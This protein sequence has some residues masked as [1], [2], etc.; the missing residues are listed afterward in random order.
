MPTRSRTQ[1]FRLAGAAVVIGSRPGETLSLAAAELCRFLHRLSGRPS[2]LSKGLPTRGAALVLDRAAAARLGVAPAA[3]EVGDQGYTLRHV[4]AGGRA[5]LVIAAATDV[6]VLYGV[7]GLLEELGMGFHAGGETYP[8]RPAPCTLPAGFEQTRRPVFPVRGNMLHY[9]FLCG[10]TDWGLDDYKF[11][12]DQLARMRCNLLLMHWYDGE[13]GAAYEFN[14]EYLAGGRTPNSLTRP[15]GALAALRTSQFSFDTARCFDAEVYSSP[16]GENLPDLLS[17]VKATETAWREATRYARTAGIRIAA[18]FEEPGGSPTDGAVCERF[19]ARLRQFLARNPHIT[20]FALW[21]HESGGCYGTT[22][23][24]A[25]TPAAALLER[26]RHLFTHLGTDRRIWEAVRYGGFAEIAAQVLAEEAPHLRLVVVGWGGDRWMRFADLCL[27]FDKMLPADVVFTCHDNIDASFGPNVSTPWG[28]L[29]PSRERWAMPWVEGDIDECWV[30][31]PHVESL[32]QLAPD[33]LRKGAQGLLTLQWRT[34]DV[35]EET[36]YIARFAWNPRLTPEQ[37]YRDLARHAFGADNEARMG[38][39]LG[40]LQCLG[41]RWSGVRGTVE[42]GHMQWTG[43]SPHFPFNL[44]ASVPPFLADM[45]D[46]AVDALSIMPRD[47]NDPEAGAF[48]A[49]RNDMSGEETVRDPS[50][51]GVR[52]MTAVAARL[53]ALA[54]E[55]DP[56]RLRA[57]LIAIEEE[58]WALRKVLVERGMSSLA[59]R[60][61]DIFLI[62]IHHLQRNAGADTH[63]PRLDELQKEL[64]TL[65]RRFVKAGRLE[66]LERLDYLAAT[67]DFVRHYDRVAMLAAAGEA[68]DRAVASA[69]TALAAGQAGRAAATAAEAYTALLEAGMQRAIEA[70]TGKLTTRCDFGTLCTLNVKLLP[71]YWETVDR[72]TRF[73]PAVPPREIQARGKADAVW[74]SWEA[75]PKAA[76]MNLYRRRAGTAAWRRVNAEPLRPACVMFTDR[77]PEPGEWEYAV[78]ALA[79]DGWESPASHLGRAVCGPTPRPRIIASKPPAWVHAGEPFDLRVVVISDRGIRRVELFVREAGKRAWRS[80]EMLPAFRESF[81]TRVPGGDLEPGL[82]EF[83]VKATDGDGGESTWPEA[84]AAGLPWSLAVLPPP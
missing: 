39:I 46:K 2:R 18:G 5:L 6:G 17:E 31:Q 24:A 55:S 13:P 80:H 37:F 68:V 74:L 26:R 25:G 81:V 84:A 10:C 62:A 8:E 14:G 12:F 71:L 43:H 75:S 52:E 40:E 21:Q 16:A 7:Y 53:R 50:R 83:V 70:F 47:E 82:C 22:P 45:V 1:S 38:H 30:R 79:A 42:C 56:G 44:D 73:F 66:R 28:E 63:L 77:P 3:D 48:H 61:F 29:P 32:G 35:E 11:Y 60:S 33:A 59:Y 54:G 69:E 36:G 27:G 58:T 19:R 20:H 67:L 41:A 64:A 15:W 78:C 23:P 76:G 72:L 51:L 49:R 57:Q 4:A 9:N 65:R 34:R